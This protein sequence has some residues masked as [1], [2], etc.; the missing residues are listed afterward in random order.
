M[1][2]DSRT[3]VDLAT[4]LGLSKTTVADA[5]R[6]SG[7]VSESTRD[8]V[9]RAA[10]DAGY[11]SNRAARQL[12]TK[13]S[14]TIGLYIG[15]D[16]RNMPFYMPFAF[17]VTDAVSKH[18]YDLT[19]ISRPTPKPGESWDHLGGAIVIDAPQNDPIVSSL[20][21]AH[22]P[23]VSA[24]RV[25]SEAAANFAAVVE[26][27]HAQVC[28]R[29]LDEL[30]L[31]GA[32]VPA[33]LVLEAEDSLSWSQ[34]IREGYLEWC[35]AHGVSSTTVSLPPFPSN[36]RVED[37]LQSVLRH[38]DVDALLFGWHEIADRATVML[39]SMGTASG[40]DIHLA[41]LTS[42]PVDSVHRPFETV[43]DLRPH[44]FGQLASETLLEIIDR[45]ELA[46]LYRVHEVEIRSRTR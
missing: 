33:L 7:R 28:H 4:Q 37:A 14:E 13:T 5:L 36:T 26:I 12:R 34:Q 8:R 6:G 25:D 41:T 10:A 24:G 22:L 17:G 15:P 18:G 1:A 44:Q 23:V 35:R 27:E 40:R 9:R 45:P 39:E 19:L 3:I 20:V 31:H 2:R 42:S 30:A 43:V 46:P 29:A 38:P 16:V 11:V 21:R 32:A